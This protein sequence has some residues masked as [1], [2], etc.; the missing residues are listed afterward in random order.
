VCPSKL[1][2]AE[3]IPS[4]ASEHAN[5]NTMVLFKLHHKDIGKVIGRSGST[6]S[7]LSSSYS[8][9]LTIG[10]WLIPKKDNR[11]ELE[12]AV[13]GVLIEGTFA[14]ICKITNDLE[15]IISEP[16]SKRPRQK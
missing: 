9:K 15:N 14:N 3:K 11:D 12:E 10:K 8:C 4:E 16:S 1:K 6:I 13:D 2:A 7:K 5:S